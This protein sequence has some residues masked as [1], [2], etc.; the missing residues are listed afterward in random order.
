M[1]FER[2]EGGVFFLLV[3]FLCVILIKNVTFQKG[4]ERRK[5]KVND[6]CEWCVTMDGFFL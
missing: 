6:V 4:I 2:V 1:I 5:R 3:C